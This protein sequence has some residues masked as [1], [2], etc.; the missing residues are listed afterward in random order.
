[1]SEKKRKKENESAPEGFHLDYENIDVSDIMAQIKEKAKA[2]PEEKSYPEVEAGKKSGSLHPNHTGPGEEMPA[3]SRKKSLLLK[4]MKPFSPAIKLL[5]LPVYQELRQ[6]VLTLDRTN[7]R[8]DVLS[9]FLN[10]ALD[11]VKS[12]LDRFNT[13]TNQRVDLALEDLT[14][15]K[16]YAKLLHNLAHNTVV[17]MTKLKIEQENLKS[18]IRILEKDFESLKNREKVLESKVIQ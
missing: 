5:V 7:K 1:M 12:S 13:D 8:L 14:R 10:S 15:A 17:E 9:G 3:P 6:T 11:E 2:L 16:E 4:L 18:R